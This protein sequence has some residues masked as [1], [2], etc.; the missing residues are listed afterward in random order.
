MSEWIQ[1]TDLHGLF[2]RISC[3]FVLCVKIHKE[4]CGVNSGQRGSFHFIGRYTW[5]AVALIR[6]FV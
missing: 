4:N 2:Q 3:K 6:V 5:R 1:G